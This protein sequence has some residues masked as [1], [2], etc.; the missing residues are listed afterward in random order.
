MQD[1]AY[2]FNSAKFAAEIFPDEIVVLDVIEGTYFS[3]GGAVPTI[4]SSL[5]GGVAIAEIAKALGEAYE[6][7]QDELRIP[8]ESLATQ[9]LSEEIL[10]LGTASD[11]ADPVSFAGIGA[12]AFPGFPVEKHEDMQDLLTLD[13]IHDVDQA[14][15]WPHR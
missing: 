12:A 15:G 9:L 6:M 5:T 13:P 7:S 14:A 1:N 11:R 8:L 10:S 3:L 2:T 4:W